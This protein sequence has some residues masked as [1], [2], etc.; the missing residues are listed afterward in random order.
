MQFVCR[1]FVCGVVV[2]VCVVV[3]ACASCLCSVVDS[4][5]GVYCLLIVC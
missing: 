4:L 2:F 1:L 5:C 3:E